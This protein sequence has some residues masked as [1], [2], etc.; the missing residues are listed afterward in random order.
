MFVYGLGYWLSGLRF[1][2]VPPSRVLYPLQLDLAVL[3]AVALVPNVEWRR[4][5]RTL[6]RGVSAAAI[7]IW[8]VATSYAV[9]QWGASGE[10]RA[11]G[12]FRASWC[13]VDGEGLRKALV[14]RNI[15]VAFVNYWTATPL[16]LANRVALRRD[17]GAARV[18]PSTRLP[19]DPRPGQRAA[20]VLPEGSPLLALFEQS[21]E[22]HAIAHERW[23]WGPFAVL[24]GLD[25][26][27]LRAGELEVPALL[28]EGS[29]PPAPPSPDGFN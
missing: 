4:I 17:P 5:P 19:D 20:V 14:R 16:A 12:S 1:L 29:R 3:L 18:V 8:L 15:D 28:E 9:I 6:A 25:A 11:S 23:R 7:A 27:Q 22:R 10:P 21:L 2:A 26:T 13:L 24:S